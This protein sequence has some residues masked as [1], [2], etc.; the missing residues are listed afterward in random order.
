MTAATHIKVKE[1]LK[2]LA[3]ELGMKLV[4]AASSNRSEKRETTTQKNVH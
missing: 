4:P 2:A 1:V 3:D